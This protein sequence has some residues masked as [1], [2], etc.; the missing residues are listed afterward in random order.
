MT[1]AQIGTGKKYWSTEELAERFGVSVNTVRDWRRRGVG[2]VACK[3]GGL[4]RYRADDV[5]R[6]EQESRE[7]TGA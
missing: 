7:D 2:P 3:L 1:V 4:V 5:D 6:W